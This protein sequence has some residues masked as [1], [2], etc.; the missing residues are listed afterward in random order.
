V[1]NHWKVVRYVIVNTGRDILV[2]VDFQD[3]YYMSEF[4]TV[5]SNYL[6]FSHFIYL[7]SFPLFLFLGT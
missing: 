6:F 4:K 1:K 2:L 5:D 3:N 7:F